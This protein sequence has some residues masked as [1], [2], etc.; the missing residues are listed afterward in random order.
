[1]PAGQPASRQV[2]PRLRSPPHIARRAM[3]WPRRS[4]TPSSA[5]TSMGQLC[6]TQRR[7]RATR[8]LVRRLQHAGAALR[9]RHAAADGAP[10]AHLK[11]PQ[12]EIGCRPGV[13]RE[14]SPADPW[15]AAF[16]QGLRELGYGEGESILVEY[17]RA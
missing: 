10:A 12:C 14:T 13:T 4:Y 16:R 11:L 7:A 2:L 9:P 15:I 1:M 8:G 17:R 6:A 3:A 5:T